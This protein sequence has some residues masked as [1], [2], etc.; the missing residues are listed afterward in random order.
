MPDLV[1]LMMLGVDSA[2]F[3]SAVELIRKRL[4]SSVDGCMLVLES[5]M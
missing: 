1:W 3:D 5:K 4:L 2:W